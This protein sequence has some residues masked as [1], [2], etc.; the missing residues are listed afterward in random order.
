[1]AEKRQQLW[2]SLPPEIKDRVERM[3]AEESRPLSHQIEAMLKECIA[4]RQ[5]KTVET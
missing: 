3:A 1:M 4:A 2:I 5:A